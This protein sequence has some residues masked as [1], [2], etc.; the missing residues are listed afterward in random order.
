MDIQ[1]RDLTT[2]ERGLLEVFQK[3]GSDGRA[4]TLLSAIALSPLRS[5]RPRLAAALAGLKQKRM[6]DPCGI[7]ALTG[8]PSGYRLASAVTSASADG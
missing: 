1:L 4:I 5:D 2:D 6:I 3:H 8:K 7:D